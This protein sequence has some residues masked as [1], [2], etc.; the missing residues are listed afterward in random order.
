MPSTDKSRVARESDERLRDVIRDRLADL[1]ISAREA[2][3]RAGFNVGYVGDILEGRS[4]IPEQDRILRLAETLE[5]DPRDLL[6]DSLP[7]G[8][9]S[10]PT[11]VLPFGMEPR[12]GGRMIPLYAASMP[13]GRPFL[14]Y[15]DAPMGRVPAP[16]HVLSAPGAYAVLVPNDV[17][18]PRFMAGETVVTKPGETPRVGDFVVARLGTGESGICRL[19]AVGADSARFGFPGLEGDAA[20]SEIPFSELVTMHRIVAA[21]Y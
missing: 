2:S 12:E 13:I 6:G 11:E 14:H 19:L 18:A 9:T 17:C 5:F 3:R 4:K 15:G 1:R 7:L 21:F 8:G 16:V 10:E 20:E